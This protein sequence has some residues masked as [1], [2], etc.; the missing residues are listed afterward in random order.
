VGDVGLTGDAFE[1]DGVFTVKGAGADIWGTN[2][3]YRRV[4][5]ESLPG[6]GE[7]VARVT[8]ED[9]ANPFAKAGLAMAAGTA[10]G[11]LNTA[12]QLGGSLGVAIF[13]AVLAT[14][15]TFQT[16]LRLDTAVTAV[17]LLVL[18]GATVRLR[19]AN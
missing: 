5:H 6:D 10:S 8:S 15:T 13:G 17:L 3:A 12:R 11:V 9:G 2:D 18:A 4:M 7:V 1:S 16:G 19:R 14:Q